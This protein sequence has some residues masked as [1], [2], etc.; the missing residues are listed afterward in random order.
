MYITLRGRRLAHLLRSEDRERF[1]AGE[2]VVTGTASGT[3]ACNAFHP[4]RYLHDVLARGLEVSAYVEM[5][6]EDAQQ[7]VALIRKPG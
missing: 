4:E 2:L 3:N 7:D 5:G 1:E 6:A